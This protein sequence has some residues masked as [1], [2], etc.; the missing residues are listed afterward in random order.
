M[1]KKFG[2]IIIETGILLLIF[3][4]V[5]VIIFVFLGKSDSFL[6]K[7]HDNNKEIDNKEIAIK[8]EITEYLVQ[9][10]KPNDVDGTCFASVENFGFDEKNE[11]V[12]YVQYYVNC[13]KL[14]DK[15][16]ERL[17]GFTEP[18]KV[19][20]KEKNGDYSV[21]RIIKKDTTNTFPKKILKKV[22]TAKEDGTIKILKEATDKKA[23]Q[24]YGDLNI[25]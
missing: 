21:S 3:I 2:K 5:F 4:A 12:L 11:F 6:V 13:Y 24:Y 22:N 8:K 10:E 23:K 19:V 9:H 20:I 7:K 17:N 14:G 18:A 25:K 1:N 16:I 15:K